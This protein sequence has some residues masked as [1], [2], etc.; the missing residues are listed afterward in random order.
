[1]S[2]LNGL[3]RPSLDSL[4]PRLVDKD[5][6]A[7]AAALSMFRGSISM[8]DGP[9]LGGVLVRPLSRGPAWRP[10][11]TRGILVLDVLRSVTGPGTG[12]DP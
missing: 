12:E 3:Q 8:I 10:G 7:A 4:V 9:A 2:A 1:M 11:L 5:E 6:T